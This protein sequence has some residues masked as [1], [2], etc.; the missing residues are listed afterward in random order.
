V[1]ILDLIPLPQS[2]CGDLQQV[3]VGITEVDAY[4]T[5]GP[6]RSPL[7]RNTGVSQMPLP[8]L[9]F[10]PRNGE[11]NVHGAVAVVRRD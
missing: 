4:A 8:F 9:Q 1:A 7:Q 3:I 11:G 6:F 5:P 2:R 10:I